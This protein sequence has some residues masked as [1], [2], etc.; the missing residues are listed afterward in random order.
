[1]DLVVL[2]LV[3]GVPSTLFAVVL[4]QRLFIAVFW[5]WLAWL[6]ALLS[7]VISSQL[8]FLPSIGPLAHSV[9][10]NAHIGAFIGFLVATA[11][12]SLG[13]RKRQAQQKNDARFTFSA[14]LL[15]HLNLFYLLVA[16]VHLTYRLSLVGAADILLFQIR[17]DFLAQRDP[18]RITQFSS[19]VFTLM[20]PIFALLAAE[21][22]EKRTVRL[23]RL[24]P[25]YLAGL[26]HGI[27]MGGRI[28]LL[29]PILYYVFSYLLL[30]QVKDRFS[31]QIILKRIRLLPVIIVLLFV[32]LGGMKSTTIATATDTGR[33]YQ[34]P[35]GILSPAVYAGVA[36]A[37]LDATAWNA[38]QVR[39]LQGQLLFSWFAERLNNMGLLSRYMTQEEVIRRDLV[40]QVDWRVSATQ[41][42]VLCLVVGD[43]GI[44]NV[45]PVMAVLMGVCQLVSAGWQGKG[46]VRQV[47]ATIAVMAAFMTVQDTWF[48]IPANAVGIIA[49]IPLTVLIHQYN[50][51]DAIHNRRA[52][53][54]EQLVNPLPAPVQDQRSK[55]MGRR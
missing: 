46:Y 10:T 1:M 4:L 8:G 40:Y 47:L 5:Y 27:A 23:K 6:F 43:F 13:K 26:I 49:T 53:L 42:T 36:L 51:K 11:L 14:R 17:Q 2:T 9:I 7:A 31:Q 48:G 35:S 24:L 28:W 16:I 29:M 50:K 20:L 41:C 25:L 21:D 54:R 44:P 22:F 33:W 12:V 15:T 34:N 39:P 30:P 18:L 52:M 32:M 3:L 37:S 45:M 55:E 38:A 19:I